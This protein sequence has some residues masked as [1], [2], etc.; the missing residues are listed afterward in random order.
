MG[1]CSNSADCARNY[2]C[3]APSLPAQSRLLQISRTFA[4]ERVQPQNLGGFRKLAAFNRSRLLQHGDKNLKKSSLEASKLDDVTDIQG[5][6]GERVVTSMSFFDSDHNLKVSNNK[7]LN[8]SNPVLTPD[9]K[10]IEKEAHKISGRHKRSIKS[11]DG[12]GHLLYASNNLER[13]AKKILGYQNT[14]PEDGDHSHHNDVSTTFTDVLFLGTPAELYQSVSVQDY[15]P[16]YWFVPIHLPSILFHTCDYV[17]KLA[18]AIALLN[19]VPCYGLDGQH[20]LAALIEI[21]FR[22]SCM[23]DTRTALE[24]LI[25]IFGSVLLFANM[26]IAFSSLW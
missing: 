22:K 8:L 4:S 14:V 10:H 9:S 5:K 7:T 12:D 19:L 2:Y 3:L 23:A 20:I 24:I 1:S 21:V 26:C 16:K 18:G 11:A 13:R 25:T 6:T 17:I 15:A